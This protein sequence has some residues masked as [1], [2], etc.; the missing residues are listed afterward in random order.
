VGPAVDLTVVVLSWNTRDLTLAALRA[1][2]TACA[3]FHVRTI[4]VDNASGDGTVGAVRHALPD[5]VV[6]E[7]GENVGYA[8]GND[9]A[10]PLVEGRAIVFLNSDAEPGAGA[11][12]HVL[13]Y[14]DAHAKVGVACPRLVFPD[15][16][17]QRAAWG[18][19][20]AMALLHQFT[21]VGWSGVGRRDARRSRPERGADERTGAVEAVSGACLVIRREL[22]ARLRGFDPGYP[23]YFED[24]DLCARAWAVGAEVHVVADGPAVVHHGGASS[25]LAEGAT[26][27]PLLTGALRF[28]RGRLSPGRYAAFTLAFKTG[29]VARSLVELLRA[30]LYATVRRLRGRR[31]RAER[32]WRTARERAHFLERDVLRFLRAEPPIG[33]FSARRREGRRPE[34]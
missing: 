6:V 22:C 15:G 9:L 32:T 29:V 23:F 25:A 27:L 5:V 13:R 14:L 19:P 1:V 7:A 18:F 16:A 31:E 8:R 11:L 17:P 21:P 26:R 2:P 28:Q 4:C 34:P 33:A 20:T 12:A 10:L 24:V 3:P 30:P